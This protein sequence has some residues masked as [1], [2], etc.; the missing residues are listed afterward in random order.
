[1]NDLISR[2]KVLGCL[3]AGAVASLVSACGGG[4]DGSGGAVD[5][6]AVDAQKNSK[7]G[8]T[9]FAVTSPAQ[10]ASA[11]ST[12]TVSGTAGTQWV[13][14]AVYSGSTKLGADVTPSG[15]K[16]STTVNMGTLAG[17]QTL[18]VMA[19]SVAAG[20][21]GGTSTSASLAVTIGATAVT[22]PAVT[23]L[24][25]WAVNCH[26]NQGGIYESMPLSQQTA[27]IQ[28]L[29]ASGARQD[30]YNISNLTTLANIVVPGMA[31]VQVIPCYIP[32]YS[33]TVAQIYAAAYA[34]GQAAASLLAGKV[35]M[36]EIGNEWNLADIIGNDQGNLPSQFNETSTAQSMAIMEGF[37]QG[38]RAG[39]PTSQTLLGVNCTYVE[40]G[41]LQMIVNNT[42]PN[43]SAAGHVINFDVVT[44]H[45]YLTGGD[46][47]STN[48]PSGVVN[49]FNGIAALTSKPIYFSECGA[50]DPSES[51]SAVEAYIP[52]QLGEMLAHSQ[53]KG[54][55]WYELF[56]Y[57]DG[58]YGLYDANGNIKAVGTAY[59]NFVTANPR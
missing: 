50:G 22:A 8:T 44:W 15:G 57:T 11:T 32:S 34:D 38:F 54:S 25:Y 53:V 12:F 7:T 23:K 31:P 52:A 21:A 47:D 2:R 18:T 19:F 48:T 1:M 40:F 37:C 16:W 33:G 56:D 39:D 46:M 28:A 36:I 13:N 4:G 29:G 10:N 45:D 58:T 20:K 42:L 24:P 3:V 59:K 49:V 5:A 17:A 43:G 35:P 6:A 55:C 30:A 26:Y 9:A 14:V 41:W 51:T 27:L